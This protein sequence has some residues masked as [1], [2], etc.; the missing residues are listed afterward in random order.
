M[1]LWCFCKVNFTY[2]LDRL[3]V[4]KRSALWCSCKALNVVKRSALWC[5]CV[6]SPS[7]ESRRALGCD[8]LTQ[9]LRGTCLLCLIRHLR[10]RGCQ[11]TV[12]PWKAPPPPPPRVPGAAWGTYCLLMPPDLL[13]WTSCQS[14]DYARHLFT[15]R[16][17]L[18]V[19]VPEK[20]PS[21]P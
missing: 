13:Y 11:H 20:S 10:A 3:D 5:S 19:D 18:R 16:L 1:A 15:H 4:G 7:L 9:P 8:Y 6:L 21:V 14:I 12:K 17:L 2:I